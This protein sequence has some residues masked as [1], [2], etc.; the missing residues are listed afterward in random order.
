MPTGYTAQVPNGISFKDF[1]WICARGM[2]DL[3]K[4]RGKSFDTP[5]P[6]RFEPSDYHFKELRNCV[7][8]L[9]S[10]IH[11][12]ESEGVELCAKEHA[13]KEAEK[14]KRL[15][16]LKQENQAFIN[17]LAYVERW[18]PPTEAHKSFKDFMNG[19][20]KT[21][22]HSEQLFEANNPSPMPDPKKWLVDKIESLV[23]DIE[24]L[25]RKHV[26]EFKHTEMAN[27][28]VKELR[29]SLED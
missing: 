27:I 17:M 25:Q 10:L 12:S 11:L 7:S 18:N 13:D 21:S 16:T 3:S 14:I 29:D 6:E 19:Q 9:N 22:I 5:V 26:E 1:V 20:L 24:Y 28:W 2:S 8:E 4:M 23:S 15:T